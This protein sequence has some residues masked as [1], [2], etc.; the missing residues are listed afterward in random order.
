MGEPHSYFLENWKDIDESFS[1]VNQ[2]YFPL[3]YETSVKS[4]RDEGLGFVVSVI[5]MND[6]M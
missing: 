1:V 4:F 3:M 5:I 2:V 6:R